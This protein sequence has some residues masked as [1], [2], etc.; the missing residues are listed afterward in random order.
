MRRPAAADPGEELQHVWALEAVDV[1]DVGAGEHGEVRGLTRLVAKPLQA[2][3]HPYP[4]L[5]AGRHLLADLVHL[6]AEPV[7][8]VRGALDE[9]VGD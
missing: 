4:Q 8:I 2:G 1:H 9:P 6:Q 5:G 7:T 3:V